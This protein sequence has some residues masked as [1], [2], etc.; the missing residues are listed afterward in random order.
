[1]NTI[2]FSRRY[3]STLLSIYIR[4]Y[5]KKLSNIEAVPPENC[6]LLIS[7]DSWSSFFLKL[8]VSYTCLKLITCSGAVKLQWEEKVR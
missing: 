6:L 8:S 2:I 4:L 5:F 1:M 7:V 3:L